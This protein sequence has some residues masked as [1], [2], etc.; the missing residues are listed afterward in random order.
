MKPPRSLSFVLLALALG[1]I[2]ASSLE[3][4]SLAVLTDGA[5]DDWGRRKPRLT[6]PAGDGAAGALD[7][8]RIW[9]AD[10]GRALFVRL[11][12]GRETLIQNSQSEAIGNRLRLYL[13]MDGKRSTGAPVAALGVDLEI[14]FGERDLISYDESGVATDLSPGTG[15]YLALPTHSSEAFEIRIELPQTAS[16]EA[17]AG[18][19]K[20]IKFFLREEIEGGDRLPN[21]GTLV[22]KLAKKPVE[23]P[24]PVDFSKRG[25]STLRVVSF[26]V[27][28]TSMARAPEAHIRLLVAL[29]PD[30]I[31]YQELQ[32][33]SVQRVVDFVDDALPD[34][35]WSGVR[36]NDVVTVSSSPILS[37]AAVDGNMVAH[38]DLPG[39]GRNLVVFNAHMPC[40]GNDAGRDQEADRLMRTWRELLGGAGPFAVDRDDAMVLL[41]DFNLVGFR[42]QLETLRD[43]VFTN[44]SNGPDF[45]PA[46][47]QG[48]LTSAPLRHTHRRLI[49]T[50]RRAESD[51][52]PGKLDF[53][54][55]TGDAL[56]MQKSLVVDSAGM[57]QVFLDGNDLRS[58]DSQEMSDH[59]PLVVDFEVLD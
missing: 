21:A 47:S 3:A 32:A 23:L 18:K 2:F 36:V 44:L 31:N 57:P 25:G 7:L 1:P 51:F 8:R 16:I 43:G 14:R 10:D 46:R 6:D 35:V 40:C 38:I 9:L 20:K 52:T 59:L 42:R 24:K 55:F 56:E 4:K 34:K 17:R 54:F 41:G 5:F 50:W 48:S 30:I 37:V 49:Q 12:V 28:D 58:P 22:Y 53:V 29:D 33:W 19:R 45:S 15:R 39:G 13:D 11:E 27:E 26:N